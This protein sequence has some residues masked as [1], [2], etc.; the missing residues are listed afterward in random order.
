MEC[1]ADKAAGEQVQHFSASN[2][3]REFASCSEQSWFHQSRLS[4]GIKAVLQLPVIA[5]FHS[6][7]FS[8]D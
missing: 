4:A 7:C 6:A 2:S 3:D 1:S 8:L 5:V